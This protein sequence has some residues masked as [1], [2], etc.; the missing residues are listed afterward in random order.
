MNSKSGPF[1]EPGENE[2]QKWTLFG[3]RPGGLREALTKKTFV[4]LGKVEIKSYEFPMKHNNSTE[5]VG[6][7]IFEI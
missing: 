7:R 5:L 1:S 3:S 4:F 6:Y 2:L